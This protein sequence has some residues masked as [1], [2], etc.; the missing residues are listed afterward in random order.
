[1]VE[2]K[3]IVKHKVGLHARPAAA[4]VQ[5]ACKFSSQITVRNLTRVG[6]PVNAKSILG[7]LT[8]GVLQN[9]EIQLNAEGPDEQKAVESLRDL[10][11]NN[12]G[13]SE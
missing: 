7:V 2:A 5:T 1:M 9:H 3:L 10:V 4:F 13:E 6:D 12:F 8:L 11:L